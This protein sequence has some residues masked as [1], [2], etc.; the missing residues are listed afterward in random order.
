[1]KGT[2]SV[3]NVA[4]YSPI[5]KL[6]QCRVLLAMPPAAPSPP[7]SVAAVLRRLTGVDITECPVCRA[8]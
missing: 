5:N 3:T 2:G 7:E 8:G 1:M 4:T 6:A